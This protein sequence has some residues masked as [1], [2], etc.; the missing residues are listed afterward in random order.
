MSCDTLRTIRL[1][2]DLGRRFGREHRLAVQTPAEAVRALCFLHPDMRRVLAEGEWRVIRRTPKEKLA[3]DVDTLGLG[4]GKATLHI[5]PAVKGRGGRGVGKA[6]LGITLVAAAFAFAFAAPLAAGATAGFLGGNWG[7]AVIPGLLTAGNVAAIGVSLT[8]AGVSAMLSPQMKTP[9][10]GAVERN[11]SYL[12]TGPA[13]TS[14]QGV[15]V[16]LIYG[17]VRVGSVLA[18]AGLVVEDF[19]SSTDISP[20]KARKL[21]VLASGRT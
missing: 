6:I 16:P 17:R 11:E 12:F 4:L 5:V 21:A 13:N 7:A 3:L 9:N 20:F 8:L 19:A 1:H 10:R 18:S 15:P 2:G 14:V